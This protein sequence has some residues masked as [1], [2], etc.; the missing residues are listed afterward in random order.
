MHDSF[1][2]IVYL[3]SS[4]MRKMQLPPD[5]LS[6][7]LSLLG[8]ET[9]DFLPALD[10]DTPVSIRLNPYKIKRNP[11]PFS[12][13]GNVQHVPWSEWG[14]YL[15]GRPAFTFDPLL[16]SG[17]YYV[18]EASS[19]FVEYIVR[20][21]VHEPVRCLDL[22]AAPGGKSVGLLSVLPE[23]SVLISNEVIRSRANVLSENLMKFGRPDVMVTH[24]APKDFSAFPAFFDL[25]LV[26][27][28]CSGEGMFRKDQVAV[29][30]WSAAN[31]RMCA[32]RQK[33]ILSDVW[34]ALRPGGLL[35]YSTCTYN[36]RENEENARWIVRELGGDFVRLEPK[37]EW[38]VSPAQSDDV[39]AWRFFPH[40]TKGEG[41]FV[42][43]VRKSASEESERTLTRRKNKKGSSV[44][45]KDR[46]IYGHFLQ[47]SGNF[48]FAEDNG[49]VF[50][51]PRK[52]SEALMLF[53]ERLNT[54]SF[55][56][57]VGEKKGRDFIPSQ[58][59]AMS[60]YL[61]PEAFP[62][63]ELSYDGAVAYLR[64]EAITLAN[65]EKGFALLTYRAEPLGFAKNIGS[66][67]NN[68]YPTEWRI[69]SGY[70]PEN[71]Y[72]FLSEKK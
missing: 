65:T 39:A 35:I 5:F 10:E 71:T 41:F 60:T 4:N 64:K 31:V 20:E 25:I 43:V 6:S 1:Y 37:T 26:D 38:N 7:I 57:Q 3:C 42:T 66:R 53:R 19:M 12:G 29:Q 56:I 68:L 47:H 61:R 33:E 28:P 17:Y 67:A 24:N 54:V 69:R 16:H 8:D 63:Y 30:E 62:R 36:L 18:Q 46:A 23:G 27:A 34:D 22:C 9:D 58:S 21:L 70:F 32:A 44:F 51:L 72:G 55:G 40:K 14:Y 49:R 52:H 13:E 2:Q 15:S 45:L 59:L 11:M 50:A 48:D